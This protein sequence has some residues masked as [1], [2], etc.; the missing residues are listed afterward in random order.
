MAQDQRG[1][2]ERKG[3]GDQV[4]GGQE[5]RTLPSGVKWRGEGPHADGPVCAC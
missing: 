5:P 1:R 2:S 4:S 3:S